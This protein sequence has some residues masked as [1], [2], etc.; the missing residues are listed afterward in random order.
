MGTEMSLFRVNQT[1]PCLKRD[2]RLE[3]IDDDATFGS[4]LDFLFCT[5]VDEDEYAVDLW[6]CTHILTSEHVLQ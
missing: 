2:R 6:T 5:V 1:Y 4:F 3:D